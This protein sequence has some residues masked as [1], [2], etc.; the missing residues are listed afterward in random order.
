MSTV[1]IKELKGKASGNCGKQKPP[2]AKKPTCYSLLLTT[3]VPQVDI[4]ESDCS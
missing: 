3:A 2:Q 1:L 4:M